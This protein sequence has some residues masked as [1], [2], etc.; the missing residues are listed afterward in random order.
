MRDAAVAKAATFSAERLVPQYE[1]LY[2]RV[3]AK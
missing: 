2:H 3:L 1:E